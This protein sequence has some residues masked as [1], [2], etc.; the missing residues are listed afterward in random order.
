MT[1]PRYASWWHCLW[2]TFLIAPHPR[3]PLTPTP[4][5]NSNP[6]HAHIPLPPHKKKNTHTRTHAHTDLLISPIAQVFA[7]NVADQAH[8]VSAADVVVLHNVFQYFGDADTQRA[9]WEFIRA[10]VARKGTVIVSV[11][12]LAEAVA[13]AEVRC[14]CAFVFIYI[15]FCFF[16]C[17]NDWLF[18]RSWPR[19][20]GYAVA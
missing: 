18:G 3:H 15:F 5:F 11:P 12:A 17:V 6:F 20:L 2:V 16:K 7:G 9:M 1:E 14:F 8:L 4:A 13:E 10:N 19:R